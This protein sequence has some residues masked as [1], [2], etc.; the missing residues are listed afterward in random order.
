MIFCHS[1]LGKSSLWHPHT[2]IYGLCIFNNRVRVRIR[3]RVIAR[4]RVR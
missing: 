3:F 2:K 1:L 4:V